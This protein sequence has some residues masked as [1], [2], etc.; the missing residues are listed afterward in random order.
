MPLIQP[1][2]YADI[3]QVLQ[4]QKNNTGNP[5]QAVDRIARELSLA[6]HKYVS[7]AT[8]NPGQVVSTSP[9]GIGAT[10]TPGTLS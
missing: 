4:N 10:T 8:V 6:I 5:D 9:A 7:A 2:L 3:K 1:N